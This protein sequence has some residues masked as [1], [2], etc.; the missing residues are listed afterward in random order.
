[1]ANINDFRSCLQQRT[2]RAHMC[3]DTI[4]QRC[5]N[6][7]QI[8]VKTGVLQ[9]LFDVPEFMMGYP[10]Y[11]IGQC[12]TY[13]MSQLVR[14]G[15]SVQYVFPKGILISWG[16][17]APQPV[18]IQPQSNLLTYNPTCATT[19]TQQLLQQ[20][21]QLLQQPQPKLQQ[22]ASKVPTDL[23]RAFATRKPGMKLT[24]DI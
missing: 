8:A 22:N 18:T 10:P 1:M 12:I 17:A 6:R 7:M 14:A 3:F 5:R 21:Q 9:I 16:C 24:L 23:Q 4:L 15:F 19:Q 2:N 20:P 11:N 13:I